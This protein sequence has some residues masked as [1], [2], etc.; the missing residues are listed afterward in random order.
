MVLKGTTPQSDP[1]APEFSAGA[2]TNGGDPYLIRGLFK[3]ELSSTPAS[4]IIL[5]AKL[6]LYSNPTPLNGNLLDANAGP[7]NAM[8]IVKE[9]PALG[10]QRFYG[11]Y[12]QL[13]TFL[14]K[15]LYRILT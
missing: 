12:S 7:N 2:W 6:T 9:I 13:S 10:H 5:S 8:Y 3:F 11:H 15:Y 1:S 4:C 14:L